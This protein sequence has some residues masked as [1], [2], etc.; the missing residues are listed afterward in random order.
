M[1]LVKLEKR[2]VTLELPVEVWDVV[3][4]ANKLAINAAGQNFEKWLSQMVL[5]AMHVCL[6][7]AHAVQT[8]MSINSP[9]GRV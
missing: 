7:A 1:G 9:G 8:E 5:D 3:D 2:Q 6:S 4:G